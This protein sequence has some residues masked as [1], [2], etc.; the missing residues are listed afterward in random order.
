MDSDEA[1]EDRRQIRLRNANAVVTD[2]DAD[3]IFAFSGD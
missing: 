3:L 1:T 2:D